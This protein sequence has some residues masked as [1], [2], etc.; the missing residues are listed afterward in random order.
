MLRKV[1]MLTVTIALVVAERPDETPSSPKVTINDH[2]TSDA[3][4][5][6]ITG[7][8][9]ALIPDGEFVTVKCQKGKS[10]AV[11]GAWYVLLNEDGATET[12]NCKHS[13]VDNK[14][15]LCLK[16]KPNQPGF[17]KLQARD[18]STDPACQKRGLQIVYSCELIES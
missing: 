7:A 4:D 14:I 12:D 13:D 15:G 8:R 18:P 1:L 11:H 3:G 2:D 10:V 17:C 16:T 6:T 9:V 5:S